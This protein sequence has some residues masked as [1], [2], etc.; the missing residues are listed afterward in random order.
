MHHIKEKKKNVT[1]S[2]GCDT[3]HPRVFYEVRFE[4]LQALTI[5]FTTPGKDYRQTGDQPTVCGI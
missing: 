4:M 2:S 5:F 3:F 1:K